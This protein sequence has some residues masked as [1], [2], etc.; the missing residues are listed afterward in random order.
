MNVIKIKRK[1][2]N[3]KEI[4]WKQLFYLFFL[5]TGE[6]N[7]KVNIS[8]LPVEAK[9]ECWMQRVYQELLDLWSTQKMGY[10]ESVWKS[11]YDCEIEMR[12]YLGLCFEQMAA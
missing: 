6:H 2:D 9:C 1:Y 12:I 3:M 11:F 5:L 7:S 8:N 4:S 10:H